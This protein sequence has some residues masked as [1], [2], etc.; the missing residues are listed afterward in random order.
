MFAPTLLQLGISEANLLPPGLFWLLQVGQRVQQESRRLPA[1]VGPAQHLI[2]GDTFQVGK[3]PDTPVPQYFLYQ[4]LD[5]AKQRK[6]LDARRIVLQQRGTAIVVF[7]ATANY[8][9]MIS[10]D[11]ELLSDALQCRSLGAPLGDDALEICG[12]SFHSCLRI[13][14]CGDPPARG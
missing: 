2:P 13:R 8:S 5:L 10:R 6:R 1:N 4:G 14:R 7:D 11:A 9:D 3:S 12:R